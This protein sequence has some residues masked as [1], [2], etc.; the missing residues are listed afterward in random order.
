[1]AREHL[2]LQHSV[3]SQATKIALI[4]SP[5]T[6]ADWYRRPPLGLGY[7]CSYLESHGLECRIFDAYFHGWSEKQLLSLV[8]SYEPDVVGFTAMTHEIVTAARLA[9]LIKEQQ[10]VPIVIGG[11]HATALPRRTMEE[12]PVFDYAIFG[13]GEQSFLSLTKSLSGNRMADLSAV[14][15][16][17]YRDVQGDIQVNEPRPYL[18]RDDL[19]ALPYPAFH[20]F[21]S[22][23]GRALAGKGAYYAIMTSRGCPYRC[24][25]CMQVLGR[26][27]RQRSAPSVLQ[28]IE[29]AIAAYGAH[30]VHFIDEIFLFD[31]AKTRAM[32][33]L[34]IAQNLPER[35]QWHG[36]VRANLV[37]PELIALAK[38]AGCTALEMGVES[39]DE[40][41]LKAISKEIT[42]RQVEEAVKIIKRA[43]I[44]VGTDYILGHPGETRQTMRKTINLAAK[45]NTDTIAV[46]LMVPYPGTRIYEM[47]QR[48]EGGYRLLTQDWSEYDKYCAHALEIEGISYR[49]MLKFQRRAL[50]NL[51]VRNFRVGD[52][53]RYFWQ[54]KRVVRFMIKKL[55]AR[56]WGRRNPQVQN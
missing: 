17:V 18:S 50:I 24:A 30:T 13:E 37:N 42:V 39:G 1:M 28:E 45:L 49:E 41:I 56:W 48:R 16:L 44:A 43:G 25:F 40:A 52:A 9:S 21:Y 3:L 33:E 55:V 51:Y 6:Y 27:V 10:A 7:I 22:A 38:R 4:R 36:R 34:M 15:G 26:K 11:C 46:G 54:R 35:I 2:R 14:Q 20:Q 5:A 53:L 31:N 12:F 8:Q 47:A 19:D 32:L 29:Y 23:D